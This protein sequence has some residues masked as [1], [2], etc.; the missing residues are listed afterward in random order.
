M[1]FEREIPLIGADGFAR[2]Q[3]SKVAVVGLGGVGGYVAETLAR[4]GVGGLTLIDGDVVMPSNLNRQI[5]ALTST[6]GMPKADAMRDR[7]A[8]I[9]PDCN[10]AAVPQMLGKDNCAKLIDGADYVADAIDSLDA[11]AELALYCSVRGVPIVSAMGAGNRA[12]F[13]NFE[14][15]DVFK[16]SYDPLAKKFRRMLRDRGVTALEVCCTSTPPTVACSDPVASV[17]YVP[18]VC[19]IRI[20]AHIVSR[21]IAPRS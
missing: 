10:V 3:A 17:A 14:I 9:A 19:G 5:V 1:S 18:S 12:D 15:K 16:T 7:I 20:A 11:K 4:C 2:L 13:C 8:D 21:L 6:I